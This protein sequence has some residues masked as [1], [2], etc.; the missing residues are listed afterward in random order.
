MRLVFKATDALDTNAVLEFIA[1]VAEK[2]AT[3]VIP[4]ACLPVL[5]SAA[6]LKPDREGNFH[7]NWPLR[8]GA[9]RCP[10]WERL[11]ALAL[12]LAFA[13]LLLLVALLISLCD[14]L[15][16]LFFQQRLGLGGVTFTLFKFRTM[17]PASEA[18]HPLLEREHGQ[19]GRLFKMER[20][21]RATRLGRFLRDTFIDELPQLA[22]VARGEMRLA[23]PRPLPPSDTRHY[24]KAHHKL[25]LR[26]LPGMT[27]LWQTSGRNALTFDEMCL[28]DIYC[29]CNRSGVLYLRLLARTLFL[30]L[31]SA[32]LNREA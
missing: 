10:V 30:A 19:E 11:F 4:G 24:T 1:A 21:P 17:H 6:R 18:Q 32:C 23:G 8:G 2:N 26:G 9:V 20:D 14:G 28:L 25:R 3:A 29:L 22:N 12:L 31:K 16:V 13:P 7:F 15:P 5:R 27:G